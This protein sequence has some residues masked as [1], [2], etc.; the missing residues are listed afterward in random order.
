MYKELSPAFPFFLKQPPFHALGFTLNKST[1]LGRL[2][3]LPFKMQS[4]L[5]WMTVAL[6]GH[7]I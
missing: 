2:S 1:V 4:H 6:S 5:Q 3:H 7:H